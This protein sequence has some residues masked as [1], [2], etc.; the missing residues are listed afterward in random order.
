MSEWWQS[1]EPAPPVAEAI[2]STLSRWPLY[3]LAIAI[4]AG[5]LVRELRVVIDEERARARMRYEMRLE[6]ELRK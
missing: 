2:E 5:V 4:I 1:W 6:Q 3:V